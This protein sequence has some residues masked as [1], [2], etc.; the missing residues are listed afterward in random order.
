MSP[1]AGAGTRVTREVAWFLGSRTALGVPLLHVMVTDVAL[2]PDEDE[3]VETSAVVTSPPAALAAAFAGA[4]LRDVSFDLA[5]GI[6]ARVREVRVP[7]G[8]TAVATGANVPVLELLD[9]TADVDVAAALQLAPA[10]GGALPDLDAL[11]GVSGHANVDAVVG[12]TRS[13]P[14]VKNAIRLDI[15]EGT[16]D[17]RQLEHSFHALADAVLNFRVKGARLELEKDI[18][19]VPWDE[20]TLVAWPLDER[21]RALAARDRVRLR[22]L[23]DVQILETGRRDAGG[24]GCYGLGSL[25]LEDIDVAASVL[26]SVDVPFGGGVVTLGAGGAAGLRGLRVRGALGC[27]RDGPPTASKLDVTV[28]AVT[29]A[30]RGLSAAGLVVDVQ[31]LAIEDVSGELSFEGLEPRRLTLNLPKVRLEGVTLAA[32]PVRG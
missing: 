31:R 11:D 17:F 27:T 32:A 16:I 13:M 3:D 8:A 7:E 14:R 6:V 15:R 18:P 26:A 12:L 9:V 2:A 10:R 23:L 1:R 20:T 30:V 21:D 24:K 22:R 28:L 29:A 19:L 5:P 25:A 4:E